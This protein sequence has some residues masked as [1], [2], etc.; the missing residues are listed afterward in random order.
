MSEPFRYWSDEESISTDL[1][2]MLRE[3][4]ESRSK[5]RQIIL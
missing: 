1:I 3:V 2:G 4:I 5:E